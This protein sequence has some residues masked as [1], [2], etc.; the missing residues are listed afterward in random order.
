MSE[1]RVC[2]VSHKE[3]WQDESGAWLSTGGFPLQMGAI[4]S[5]FDR[6]TLLVTRRAEPGEGGIALPPDAEVVILR[7]P[8]GED[9]TRKLFVGA[10]LLQY[11]SVI[12]RHVRRAD[13]VHVPPPGD[14]S[15][16]GMIVGLVLRKRLLVR[17]CGSWFPTS[18][19]TT[20]NRVT[21]GLMRHFAGGR[22][23]M[24]A[25]GMAGAPPARRMNWIFATAST[26]KEAATVCPDLDRPPCRPLRLVYAGRI[27][28]EKGLLVL[29]EALRWLAERR[30][31]L[32]GRLEMTVAGDGPDRASLEASVGAS[33]L[34]EIVRFA[35]QLDRHA[36]TATLSRADVCVL[37]SLSE[38]FCKA[39]VEAMLCGTPVLTT[40]VGFGRELAGPD[41]ERGWIVPT[42]D[43][44]ELAEAIA[45]LVEEPR[46]WPALRRR[47]HAFARG[48]TLE[49]WA[50]EIGRLCASQWGVDLRNGKIAL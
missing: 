38:S 16:L 8:R 45:R 21:Q 22:N 39:R 29:V 24:L 50:S 10:H 17:Y 28:R 9:L 2:V 20:M 19:T 3:C 44:L 47:C 4:A 36:L 11:L 7:K 30:W 23:V 35:G 25:T 31:G 12:A 48:L 26:E 49:A 6:M 1:T 15:L 34:T 5:L 33:G 27:S 46:D 41:G 40:E 37:P 18:E 13:V 32:P 43:A 42:G 14:I